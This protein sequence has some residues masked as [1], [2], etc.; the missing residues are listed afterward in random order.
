[1]SLIS[2]HRLLITTAIVFCGGFALWEFDNASAG[3][4]AAAFV[5]GTVFV[6]LAGGLGVYL[7][8]LK[9]FLGYDG[10]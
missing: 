7:K 6:V 3:G 2:F 10:T 8:H 9:R 5:I 4:G 1:M